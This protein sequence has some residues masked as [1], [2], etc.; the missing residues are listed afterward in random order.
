MNNK[1]LLVYEESDL[2]FDN[3][4]Q[5]GVYSMT[6]NKYNL[7]GHVALITGGGSGIGRAIAKAFLDNGALVVLV[8]RREEA[9]KETVIDY[10]PESYLILSG[11]ISK[12]E[13]ARYIV[14]KSLSHFKRLDAVISDAAAFVAGDIVDLREEE[15]EHIRSTNID[16]F[17]FLAKAS[18][19][20]LKESKGNLIAVS[21]V[22]GSYGDWKQSAYNASKHAVNGFVKSLALD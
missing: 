8:G 20:A 12:P 19:Y 10:S 4:C 2:Q 6:V 16:G 21:S 13:T 15:W 9:L 14:E 1:P 11:D 22:S 18:Y 5:K 17:F 3:L 7:E